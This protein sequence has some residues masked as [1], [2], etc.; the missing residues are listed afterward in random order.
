MS[1]FQDTLRTDQFSGPRIDGE[2]LARH[3]RVYLGALDLFQL[4]LQYRPRNGNVGLGNAR[5]ALGRRTVG[6][7]R[8]SRAAGPIGL[9]FSRKIAGTQL[10]QAVC[11]ALQDPGTDTACGGRAAAGLRLLLHQSQPGA[12]FLRLRFQHVGRIG[13]RE[14][15][16]AGNIIADFHLQASQYRAGNRF[17]R[18]G[19]RYLDDSVHGFQSAERR[20]PQRS[21]ADRLDGLFRRRGGFFTATQSAAAGE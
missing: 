7:C 9:I 15:L 4:S 13:H 20:N 6:I 14:Q 2:N 18:R 8:F 1:Q 16:A 21:S 12:G 11:L 17:G 10:G 5:S 19:G 3:R